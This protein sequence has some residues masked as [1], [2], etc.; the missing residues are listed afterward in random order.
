[1]ETSKWQCLGV[2]MATQLLFMTTKKK[3]KTYSVPFSTL[4]IFWGNSCV[5]HRS[6][7]KGLK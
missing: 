2:A 5:L 7:K 4:K 1:M 3:K 6:F